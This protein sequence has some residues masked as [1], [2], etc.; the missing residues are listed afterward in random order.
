[1]N[2]TVQAVIRSVFP[3][4]VLRSL[5]TLRRKHRLQ[6]PRAGSIEFGDFARLK[7]VSRIFGIDRGQVIDRYYIEAFLKQNASAITGRCLELG[8]PYYIEKF[9][10]GVTRADVLH[11]VEGN[12]QATIV[13]DLT[14]A[15]HIADNTFDCIIFTQTIQMIYEP[16][17]AFQT[18]HRILKPGG[19][20]LVTSAGIAKIG[21]RLGRDPWGE[22]W[23][24]TAQSMDRMVREFWPAEGIS[25]TTYGNV[26]SACCFL[27]GLAAEELL[28]EQ[29]DARDEDFEVIV[30]ARLQKERA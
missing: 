13:G 23:H 9:G 11:Y 29:L 7:P 28:P 15:P 16:R 19:V 1:M 30:A 4:D 25:V 5:T 17:A 14:D 24:F 27:H 18:L 22:Y 3:N 2:V 8:D 6:W 21:R 10:Q 26:M 20:A 12:P